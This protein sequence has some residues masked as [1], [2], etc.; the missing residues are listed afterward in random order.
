MI[1]FAERL[2]RGAGYRIHVEPLPAAASGESPER[3]MN[4]SLEALIRSCP[5]QYLWAYNRYKV[6]SGVS[7]PGSDPLAVNAPA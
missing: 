5:E 6:P 7:A 4:R 2:P 1:A 3:H